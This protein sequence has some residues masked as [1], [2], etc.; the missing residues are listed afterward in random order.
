MNKK[1]KTAVGVLAVLLVAGVAWAMLGRDTV[2]DEMQREAK[3]VFAEGSSE[4]DRRAFREKVGQLT[5][6][7]RREL[8]QRGRPEMQKRIATRMNDIMNLPPEALRQEVTGRADAVLAA[9]AERAARGDD[10]G[11]GGRPPGPPGGRGNGGDRRK[12]MLDFIPATTRAQFTA[13]RG[14]VNQELEAR[15]EDPLSGRDMR[16]MFRGGRG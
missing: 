15:G 14:M 10:G 1:T 13:F 3:Q 12:Q 5:E 7:Q 6:S 16:A 9:R 11:R 2:V 8:W 4:E